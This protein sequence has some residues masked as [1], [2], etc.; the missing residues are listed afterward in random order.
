MSLDFSMRPEWEAL[1]ARARAVAE[2]GVPTMAGG[3]TRG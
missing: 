2:Q 1:R 3:T